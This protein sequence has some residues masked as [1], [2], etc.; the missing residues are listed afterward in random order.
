MNMKKIIEE[1]G[2]EGR[3]SNKKK[4]NES[5]LSFIPYPES[6]PEDVRQ[7]QQ[8][9]FENILYSDLKQRIK[10]VKSVHV[11][12]WFPDYPYGNTDVDLDIFASAKDAEKIIKRINRVLPGF[13]FYKQYPSKQ[14]NI[15]ILNFSGIR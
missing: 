4:N 13:E 1:N 7:Q 6:V 5:L 15:V 14:K 11:E 3:K 12:F 8:E 10:S 2:L 9:E